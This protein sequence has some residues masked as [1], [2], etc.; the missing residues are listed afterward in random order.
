MIASAL[1]MTHGAETFAHGEEIVL[2]AERVHAPQTVERS[3]QE[4][5]PGFGVGTKVGAQALPSRTRSVLERTIVTE[6]FELEHLRLQSKHGAQRPDGAGRTF[7]RETFEVT[8]SACVVTIENLIETLMKCID[9]VSVGR[10][11]GCFGGRPNAAGA[12]HQRDEPS[13]EA[14]ADGCGRAACGTIGGGRRCRYAHDEYKN[15]SVPTIPRSLARAV[16][17]CRQTMSQSFGERL[18]EAQLL[19]SP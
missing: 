13:A 12:E 6:V 19:G 17:D 18:V 11:R 5:I 16:F 15:L 4:V 14:Q 8:S 3:G 10:E 9:L 1:E 2:L 7:A